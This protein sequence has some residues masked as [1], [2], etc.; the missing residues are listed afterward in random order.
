MWI[1]MVWIFGSLLLLGGCK[2]DSLDSLGLQSKDAAAFS[3]VDAIRSLGNGSVVVSWM[4]FDPETSLSVSYEVLFEELNPD[5]LTREQQRKAF[6]DDTGGQE[7][8]YARTVSAEAYQQLMGSSPVK[9]V[10]GEESVALSFTP[11]PGAVYALLVR[12]K[13]GGEYAQLKTSYQV[14]LLKAKLDGFAG[15]DSLDFDESRRLRLNWSRLATSSSSQVIYTI[16]RRIV[17]NTTEIESLL[18]SGQAQEL[19]DIA[20]K[21]SLAGATVRVLQ[22]PNEFQPQF[23]T[24]PIAATTDNS[25]VVKQTSYLNEVTLLQV[26][27]EGEDPVDRVFLVRYLQED[28]SSFAGITTLDQTSKAQVKLGWNRADNAEISHYNIY[29]GPGA[30][31]LIKT[32]TGDKSNVIIDLDTE[33]DLTWPFR[34]RASNAQGIEDNN[35]VTKTLDSPSLTT[36]IRSTQSGLT[37]TPSAHD[38]GTVQA[39]GGAQSKRFILSYNSELASL[40]SISSNSSS[41]V[42]SNDTCSN[43][44]ITQGTTCS[45]LITFAPDSIGSRNAVITVP[46]ASK[47]DG[48][49]TRDLE[50]TFTLSGIGGSATSNFVGVEG[51]TN[52]NS[53]SVDLTWTHDSAAAAYLIYKVVG[54]AESLLATVTAPASGAQLTGLSAES[55]YTIKVKARDSNGVVAENDQTISFTTPVLVSLTSLTSRL[56][57][58]TPTQVG[59]SLSFD[60][61]NSQDSGSNTTF[62]CTFDTT[63]DGAVSAGTSC[64]SL[65][66]TVASSNLSDDGQLGWIIGSAAQST[67]YEIRFRGTVGIAYDD[68]IVVVQVQPGYSRSNL[69][70]AADFDF[71]DG[72]GAGSN[73]NWTAVTNSAY[74]NALSSTMALSAF[75]DRTTSSG[76]AGSGTS[77]SPYQLVFDGVD[78]FATLT[79]VDDETD[80]FYMGWLKPSDIQGDFVVFSNGTG[81]S[82]AGLQLEHR[83]IDSRPYYIFTVGGQGVFAEYDTAVLADSPIGYWRLNTLSNQDVIPNLGNSVNSIDAT[84]SGGTPS[85]EGLA[86]DSDNDKAFYY[87]SGDH[88]VVPQSS[89]YI[90]TLTQR[91]IET[92]FKADTIDQASHVAGYGTDG[93]AIYYGMRITLEYGAVYCYIK[94]YFGGDA[95]DTNYAG[96]EVIPGIAYHVVSVYDETNNSFKCFVNGTLVGSETAKMSSPDMTAHDE[97]RF[98]VAY[99]MGRMSPIS[100]RYPHHYSYPFAG[101]I[102]DTSLY[103]TALSTTRAKAHY[104]P[105]NGGTCGALNP[106]GADEWVHLAVGYKSNVGSLYIN[107]TKMCEF[108]TPTNGLTN[109]STTLTVG[110][111]SS[112]SGFFSG[113]LG[114]LTF[115]NASSD[116]DAEVAAHYAAT[117]D[118]YSVDSMHALRPKMVAWLDAADVDADG[119]LNDQPTSGTTVTEWKDKTHR[120]NHIDTIVGTPSFNSSLTT[121]HVPGMVFSSTHNSADADH[122]AATLAGGGAIGSAQTAVVAARMTDARASWNG[123]LNWASY[124]YS[125]AIR[126]FQLAHLN[127]SFLPIQGFGQNI[128][129]TPSTSNV[130]SVFVLRRNGQSV[131]LTVDGVTQTKTISEYADFGASSHLFLGALWWSSLGSVYE[132]YS[133]SHM[134]GEIYEIQLYNRYLSDAEVSTL[135]SLM[136]AKWR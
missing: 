70:F 76:F 124:S 88:M 86:Q 101:V 51:Y 134:D 92:W 44:F 98:S 95:T 20:A 114:L 73:S 125:E 80:F 32:V 94:E 38:F 107:G 9:T 24:E 126:V 39:V 16:Y 90:T 108:E 31:Q 40:E 82:G 60:V 56:L 75:F 77:G 8:V 104:L 30:T 6:Q 23:S 35:S 110:A 120:L 46:Y 68:E 58:G 66:G 22:L 21:T 43:N 25:F 78:D 81:S 106:I 34:V 26:M 71:V 135:Q 41:Y 105:R 111:D 117:K 64:A 19:E 11:Q 14:M 96:A 132:V 42:I 48:V 127:G 17:D 128:A 116:L 83:Y 36:T 2:A 47:L 50:L 7:I 54:A 67:S 29:S 118:D 79:G 69:V 59:D 136:E 130:A 27:I 12:P 123:M 91:S 112:Q 33:D 100:S 53:T 10:V 49:T 129:Y 52:L 28:L 97:E 93:N 5:V 109:G 72:Y 1:Q 61:D 133:D 74:G 102:D 131:Q 84:S 103:V 115:Y 37:V 18:A 13:V 15:V 113:S 99:P 55:S 45:L 65:P 87:N 3:G 122:M 85:Q 62:T 121:A 119:L 63:V 57:S 89:E 4:P